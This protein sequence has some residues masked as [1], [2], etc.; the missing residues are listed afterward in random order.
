MDH[1]FFTQQLDENQAGWDWLSI[2][3]GDN[4]EVM[5]YQIRRKD[6]TVDPFSSGTFVDADGRS[7]YL[8]AADFT[9]APAGEFWSSPITGARY[10]IQW[11]IS[12]P[13]MGVDLEART[14]LK[15][16][17]FTGHTKAAPN[18]WEGAIHLAGHRGSANLTGVGYLEMT[19]YDHPIEMAQ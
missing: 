11:R 4:T 6:G 18:Y 5:L 1:E 7:T 14:P 2:Q 13:K 9:V 3:L 15:S 17:E 10:P 16:Q 8:R 19:G 12:I